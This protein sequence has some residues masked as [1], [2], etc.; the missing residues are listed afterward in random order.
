[1]AD[2]TSG[3]VTVT[4]TDRS[5]V[6]KKRHSLSNIDFGDGVLT[7]PLLGVP[8]PVIGQFALQLFIDKL[9]LYNPDSTNGLLW[10]YDKTNHKLRGYRSA[11]Y[12]PIFTGN[13]PGLT[14]VDVTD[15]DAAAAPGVAL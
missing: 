14:T 7:Y 11:A 10:K 8:L 9:D 4:V 3:D 15:V 5:R 1:M 6:G 2:I 13:A 12:T